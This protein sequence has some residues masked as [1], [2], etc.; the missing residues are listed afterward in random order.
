MT[1]EQKDLYDYQLELQKIELQ[2]CKARKRFCIMLA[3]IG[4]F[5]LLAIGAIV[6]IM[7]GR[8]EAGTDIVKILSYAL[9]G[10]GS[11][12]AGYL[13]KVNGGHPNVRAP[14]SPKPPETPELIG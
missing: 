8:E 13:V 12:G 6:A 2:R 10:G 9:L 4:V 3:A 11:Y 14:S 7:T 1:Q 5:V